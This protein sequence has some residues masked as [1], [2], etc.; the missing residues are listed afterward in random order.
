MSLT[1]LGRFR[2]SLAIARNCPFGRLGQHRLKSSSLPPRWEISPTP[3]SNAL[4]CFRG[5]RTVLPPSREQV[6]GARTWLAVTKPMLRHALRL[7][8]RVSGVGMKSVW[9]GSRERHQQERLSIEG[10][11]SNEDTCPLDGCLLVGPSE[12]R[13][14][15]S[16]P[17][18]LQLG[19]STWATPFSV[20]PTSAVLLGVICRCACLCPSRSLQVTARGLEEAHRGV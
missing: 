3:F 10:R 6:A 18:G 4:R 13:S 20:T 9:K 5:M 1:N 11:G 2:C 17:Q 16:P 7:G 12:L 19:D 8:L 15:G 14:G